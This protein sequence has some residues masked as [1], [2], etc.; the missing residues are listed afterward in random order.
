MVGLRIGPP[1]EAAL[2]GGDAPRSAQRR[3]SPRG[4]RGTLHAPQRAAAAGVADAA[5]AAHCTNFEPF[6]NFESG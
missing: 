5:A 4:C 3:R 1:L 2:A 6:R